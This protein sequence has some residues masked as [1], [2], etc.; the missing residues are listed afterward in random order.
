MSNYLSIFRRSVLCLAV[1]LFALPLVTQAEV[2]QS[3]GPGPVLNS[4]SLKV[5]LTTYPD[6]VVIKSAVVEKGKPFT[7]NWEAMGRDT[8]GDQTEKG[9][10]CATNFSPGVVAS[11]S[12]NLAH[13]E[14]TASRSFVITCSGVGASKTVKGKVEVGEI[15]LTVPSLSIV[16]LTKGDKAGTFIGGPGK[17]GTYRALVKN[18]GKLST[19][20]PFQVS[21]DFSTSPTPGS[22]QVFKTV[23]MKGIKGNATAPIDFSWANFPIS[24]QGWYYRVCADAN[25]G[26]GGGGKVVAESNEDNNC[27]KVLGPVKYVAAD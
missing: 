20:K 2:F 16:G 12:E 6:N 9:I 27:S 25:T 4:L 8:N 7:I 1:V 15:D 13:G 10:T 21:I 22:G 11:K 23:S 24:S 19:E 18:L 17:T 5:W 3:I 26:E 14:I